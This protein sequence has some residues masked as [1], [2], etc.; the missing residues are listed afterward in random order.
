[1]RPYFEELK[2]GQFYSPEL[3]NIVFNPETE[4]I[5][6]FNFTATPIPISILLKDDF[7]LW[8]YGQH[9]YKVGV[10]KMENKTMYNWHADSNRGV[11]VNTMIPT[12]NTSYTFF[13]DKADVQHSVTEL[14]YY[15]GTRFLFNN[16]KEHMVLNYDGIRM[17]LT[18]EFLE[19][20]NELTFS[21]LLKEIE[22]DYYKK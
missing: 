14:Q 11:C 17:M 18:I 21:Q 2:V 15:P 6:Y 5:P 8:L 19:D 20:K 12:P 16:Q 3:H 9:K 1:M 4:W 10:L 22:N 13:R 7:Y